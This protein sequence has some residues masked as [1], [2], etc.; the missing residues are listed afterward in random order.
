MDLSFV[1]WPI[2]I[3][4][5]VALGW[6]TT[7][8]GMNYMYKQSTKAQVGADAAKDKK[9]EAMLSRC[10]GFLLFTFRPAKADNFFQTAVQ[11]YPQGANVWYNKYRMVKCA[12]K[13][14]QYQRAVNQ[15]QEL[16]NAN[17]STLDKR[18]AENANLKLR[19]DKLKEMYGLGE[20][21]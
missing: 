1:K 12:E 21:R 2:I 14:K 10:G 6:L 9:D 7:S 16:I 4:V 3:I 17:A 20:M 18:V 8:G 15:L 19:M 13:A 11:R 5:V